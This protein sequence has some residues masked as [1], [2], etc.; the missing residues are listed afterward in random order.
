MRERCGWRT[1]PGPPALGPAALAALAAFLLVLVGPGAPPA[2]AA[3]TLRVS[4]AYDGSY[5]PGRPLAVRVQVAADR[6]V[7]GRLDVSAGGGT[8]VGIPVEIPGGSNKEFL[9]VLPAWQSF[10]FDGAVGVLARLRDGTEEVAAANGVVQS[11]RGQELVGLLPGALGG[12]GVPGPAPLAIDAG[13]ARFAAVG[14]AELA[15]APGSLGPVSTLAAAAD[16]LVRLPPAAT[17]AI[18]AW[19]DQGGHLL[20]DADPGQT[21]AGLPAAWQPGGD[22]RAAAGRGEVRLTGGAIAGGRWAGLVEPT[23]WAATGDPSLRFGGGFVGQ[24][25]ANEAGLQV[26]RLGWLVT[27]L[28]L[29]VL[30]AGPVVFLV[31]RRQRRPELAWV[32]VPLVAVMFTAGAYVGGRGLRNTTRQVATSVLTTG[33]MGTTAD[34]WT[35]LFSARGQTSR[36]LFPPGWL[37]GGE[38]DIQ[39]P[40]PLASVTLT[41]DG[42]EAT[43]PLDPG[44]FGIVPAAGPVTADGA[45]EVTGTARVADA[46]SGR[47]RN[48][49]P[50]PLDDVAVFVGTGGSLVGHLEAGEEREWTVEDADQNFGFDGAPGIEFRLWGGFSPFDTRRENVTDM[51]LWETAKAYSGQDFLAPGEVVAAGWTRSFTPPIKVDGHEAGSGGRSLVLGR[52]R[53]SVPADGA[54]LDVRREVVRAP[55][56][57]GGGPNETVVVRFVTGDPDRGGRATDP[58]RL[59]VRAPAPEMEVWRD[60]RWQQLAAVG[61]GQAGS[62]TAEFRVPPEAVQGN[63]VHVRFPAFSSLV[64]VNGLFTLREAP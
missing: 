11:S 28:V 55:D 30:V 40:T 53:L 5:V 26:P 16:E 17:T 1:R 51:G 32:A 4:G 61:G 43:I 45:L 9:V 34:T 8:P 62:G 27:F 24:V 20:V 44:Q 46:A 47:V 50:W 7:R 15:Q 3:T 49:T 2:A 35:G 14:A 19:V 12:R 60:G 10:R 18:L 22:G 6:L 36:L 57:R 52:A 59:L 29:Y 56:F 39:G 42:A 21:V 48:A 33:A 37:P 38:S 41:A 54:A 13:T 64:D 63:V 58:A 31:V 23:G 25:L